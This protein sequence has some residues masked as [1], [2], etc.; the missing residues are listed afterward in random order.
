[1]DM[2]MCSVWF[3][4]PSLPGA[5][6]FGHRDDVTKA[7]GGFYFCSRAHRHGNE[8][9]G[10]SVAYLYEANQYLKEPIRTNQVA[11]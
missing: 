11:L 2:W 3:L 9:L 10:Q 6:A 1:M 8:F 4:L 5:D 7:G